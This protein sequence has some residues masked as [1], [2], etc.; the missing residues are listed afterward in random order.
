MYFFIAIIL[1]ALLITGFLGY[2]TNQD[3]QVM[4]DRMKNY[5]ITYDKNSKQKNKD[6]KNG[7]SKDSGS[8]NS[9]PA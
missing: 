8:K 4:K 1:L 9:E 5:R 6:S 3:L 2:S 7:D